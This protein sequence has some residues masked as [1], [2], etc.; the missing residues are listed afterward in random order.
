MELSS[1]KLLIDDSKL[2]KNTNISYSPPSEPFLAQNS[3][4]ILLINWICH[5]RRALFA[6]LTVNQRI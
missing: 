6:I 4:Q 2:I 3:S 1:E 5:M